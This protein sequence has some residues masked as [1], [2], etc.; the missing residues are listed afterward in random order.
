VI[1]AIGDSNLYPACTE[2]SD[3]PD[4]ANIA[5][6]FAKNLNQSLRCWSK[7]GASNYWIQ[8]HLEY[9]LADP[10]WSEDTFLFVGWTSFEREEW[11]WLYSN[12]SV[13][14]GPDFGIPEPMKAKYDQWKQGLTED[15]LQACID[16]WHERIYQVHEVLR[17]NQIPHLFW[18]TY[19]NFKSITHHKDWH[20]NFYKPY[21][22]DGC[23]YK[24]FQSRKINSV[25]G[26]PFHYN[27][28]AHKVWANEL[29]AF[30]GN[31]S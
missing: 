11:P 16:I 7:N 13:C 23:M 1:L 21:D 31:K 28:Q 15:Y 3:A 30:V 20:G 9:F 29:S 24:F 19:D 2:V 5:S 12:I 10:A 22:D 17:E 8:T 25:D 26:D 18:T 4:P 14:G 27:D 6:V